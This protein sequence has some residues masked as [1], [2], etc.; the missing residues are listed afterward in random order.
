VTAEVERHR[1]FRAVLEALARPGRPQPSPVSAAATP[2]LVLSAIWEPDQ[3]GES[4]FVVHGDPEPAAL[5]RVP[6]GTEEEP[7][8]GGT[9]L[10]VAAPDGPV[11]NVWL[12]GPG[13]RERG[14]AA[15]PLSA[16]A[17]AA[18]A[19]ACA[20]PPAGIDLVIVTPEGAI[21]GLPRTTAL[22]V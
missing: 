12:E 15:L 18:R 21:V 11:S 10:V 8:L 13:L 17:L 5:E 1:C 9:V 4:V 19:R 7:E 2:G 16:A 22:E 6:R 20:R 14:R 3:V